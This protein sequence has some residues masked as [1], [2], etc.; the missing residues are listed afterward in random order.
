MRGGIAR[1]FRRKRVKPLSGRWLHQVLSTPAWDKRRTV[2]LANEPFNRRHG[3]AELGVEN[4]C[5]LPYKSQEAGRF[6]HASH[7][8]PT[9]LAFS[10]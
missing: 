5:A 4:T 9:T 8:Q 10:K 2:T 6:G 1:Q 3:F 7:E